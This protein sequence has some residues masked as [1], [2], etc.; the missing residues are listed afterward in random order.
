MF[1]CSAPCKVKPRNIKNGRVRF[2]SRRH[3]DRAKYSCDAGFKLNGP[4]YITCREGKWTEDNPPTCVAGTLKPIH[5]AD[6][7]ATQLSS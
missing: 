2:H 6:T 7:D 3:G 5:T 4:E 1:L